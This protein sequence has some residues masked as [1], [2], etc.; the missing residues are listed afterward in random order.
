MNA[1][2]ESPNQSEIDAKNA[3]FWD[4]MCGSQL[5]KQLGI[6]DDSP[7]SLK[8]FDDWYFDFYPYL[9]LH[10]PFAEMRG[11]KVLE[12]GLG[13]GTV[14]QKIAEAGAHYHGLDIA[15]GP[16]SMAR[17]RAGL[18]GARD[19]DI[20]QGSILEPPFAEESLDWVV[21]IGCLHH[22]GNLA[23]AIGNVHTLLRPGGQAM[24]MVY[25]A[26]S[27]RQFRDAF[28]KTLV[29]KLSGP[30][31]SYRQPDADD[32][33]RGAYDKN[34]EGEAAPQT[35]FVTVTELKQ[36]CRAFS[37][38]TITPENIAKEEFPK[39]PLLRSRIKKMTRNQLC[40]SFGPWVGLD[41]YCRVGK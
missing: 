15:N 41:L 14:A 23:Q 24:I 11:K 8:R 27:Y 5:A 2:S 1:P 40:R 39:L 18:V 16:V 12:I 6:T 38:C 37:T 34:A 25:N 13:Y 35:E 22:T 10:I 36:L 4:E 21:A 19:A 17:H 20:R 26:A 28:L 32:R 3:A 7:E 33:E 9:F 30:F 31:R 29:R